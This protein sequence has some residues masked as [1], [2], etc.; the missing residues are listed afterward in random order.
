[1]SGELVGEACWLISRRDQSEMCGLVG[2]FSSGPVER[3][4][5][6]AAVNAIS[7]RGP[8]EKKMWFGAGINLGFARLAIVDPTSRGS[9]PMATDDGR[10]RIVFNGEIYNWRE[11]R[12]EL[13]GFGEVFRTT[14]DTEV[15]LVGFRRWGDAL[16]PR[17]NGM[18]ALA[19]WDEVRGQLFL[20]RDRL[21]KKPLFYAEL[22]DGFAF[23]SEMKA[24]YPF[25]PVV[26]PSQSF[27]WAR[28][29]LFQYENTEKTLIEGISRLPAGHHLVV[30][31]E[32]RKL[33]KY[34]DTL[35]HLVEVPSRYEDRVS[36]FRELFIDSCRLRMQSD[37]PMAITLSSGI[38]SSAMCSVAASTMGGASGLSKRE[39]EVVTCSFKGSSIDETDHARATAADLGLPLRV[40]EVDPL[41]EADK[42]LFHL[43]Q[44]EELYITAPTPMIALY[45]SI[46]ASGAK[47]SIDGHGADELLG[48]Y[49]V[50]VLES[51]S[52]FRPASV[53][54]AL[55]TYR[56]M[57]VDSGEAFRDVTASAPA[58]AAY[59]LLKRARRAIFVPNSSRIK[60]RFNAHLY[61][62]VHRSIL[63]TLLR[64]YDRYSMSSSVEVRCPFLDHR[65]VS[66][67]FSLP[68][69]DKLGQGFTKRILR[70]A[71]GDLLPQA[72]RDRKTKLGWA[73]PLHE[74]FRGP[75]RQL[76]EDEMGSQ[77]FRNCE[78]I[79]AF[80][81][82]SSW[83]Q[84]MNSRSATL[85]QGQRFWAAIQ[86]Y[87]WKK[88]LDR[89]APP[90]KFLKPA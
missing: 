82:R 73:A 79:D 89:Y 3:S 19:I 58:L 49:G 25:L 90:K 1:M 71:I 72:T 67:C 7:H 46:A 65:L 80:K 13:E 70:D 31:T 22:P 45:R 34:W 76:M 36:I 9:Q 30:T 77:D 60:E 10:Y 44:F 8:D 17:L 87:L 41:R 85:K 62:L 59:W 78:L 38:D 48:G 74:W 23:G 61:D 53:W 20:S 15:I 57:F 24:L 68:E 28:D 18:W 43:Y 50:S 47:V 86:P 83:R 52:V 29:H 32:S 66:Y 84:L 54:N 88:A 51:G 27:Q 14:C 4:L 75:L 12:R 64:N 55:E 16:F 21:G 5:V 42:L 35:E 37:A 56:D 63:P 40:V 6:E 33:F 26:K 69:Q 2:V 11:V 81:V 39:I